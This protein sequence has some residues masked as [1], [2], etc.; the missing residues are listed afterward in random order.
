LRNSNNHQEGES[1]GS[2]GIVIW[3]Y[4][5]ERSAWDT[6]FRARTAKPR[7]NF[8]RLSYYLL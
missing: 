7:A 2:K 3:T 4:N 6:D 8:S 1:K 5:E